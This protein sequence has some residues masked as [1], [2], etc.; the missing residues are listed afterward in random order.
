MP[1]VSKYLVLDLGAT[2]HM[3][4]HPHPSQG[5]TVQITTLSGV[6]HGQISTTTTCRVTTG[7]DGR[8]QWAGPAGASGAGPRPQ[9]LGLP[10]QM[11][12]ELNPFRLPARFRVGGAPVRRRRRIERNRR[13]RLILLFV[14]VRD[15]TADKLVCVLLCTGLLCTGLLFVLLLI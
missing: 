2:H 5:E 4:Y 9:E 8:P 3:F 6:T 12:P 10:N 1:D 14:V 15:G 11:N 7:S 13:R